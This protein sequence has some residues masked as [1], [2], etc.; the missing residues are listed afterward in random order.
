MKNNFNDCL[1]R[2][3][4]DEG[5]YTNDP[6]DNGGAT[7]FGITIGDYRKYINKNA[8]ATDVKNMKVEDAKAIY[9][10]KYWDSLGCDSL[11]SGVDYTVFDYGVNSGLGRP[12]KALGAFKSLSGTKLIEAINN[13]R[14][15]FLIE[16][17]NKEDPKYA[18]NAKYR[19]G[20]LARV[21]RVNTYSLQLAK[22]DNVSGPIAGTVAGGAIAASS[23]SSIFTQHP[24]ITVSVGIALAIGIGLIVHFIRNKGKK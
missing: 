17:S 15:A 11:P 21:A 2:L 9:K 14:K 6:S 23:F 22:K 13:E 8:T 10:A 16:I 7:N 3:L 24:Y 19:A 20:W 5:G 18:H 4:K 1:I 12:R